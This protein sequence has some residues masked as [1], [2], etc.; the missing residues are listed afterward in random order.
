MMH[1][2]L[3]SHLGKQDSAMELF[4]SVKESLTAKY[5]EHSDEVA[6]ALRCVGGS[7][8]S[9]GQFDKAE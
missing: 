7:L 9:Y 2:Y 4:L 3:Y 5:G 6:L 8:S 1:D